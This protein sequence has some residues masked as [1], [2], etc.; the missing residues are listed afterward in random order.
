MVFVMVATK[1]E[2]VRSWGAALALELQADLGARP[3]AQP[4][5]RGR[6]GIPASGFS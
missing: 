5:S 3:E 6:S 4:R 2:K 1:I